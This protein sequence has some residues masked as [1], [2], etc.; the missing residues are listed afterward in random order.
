MDKLGVTAAD[1][2]AIGITNQRETSVI[3]DKAT[4]EPIANAIV[5]QCR[6]TAPIV[7]E[8]G[9]RPGYGARR[10][11]GHHRPRARRLLLRPAR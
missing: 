2:A 6:R 5:W 1:I 11:R 9:R 4:G 3:W 10:I 7:E 8:L